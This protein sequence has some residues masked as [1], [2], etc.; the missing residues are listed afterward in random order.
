MGNDAGYDFGDAFA[1][2]TMLFEEA[3]GVASEGQSPR[4]GAG[5]RLELITSLEVMLGEAACIFDD[6]KAAMKE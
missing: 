1:R 5:S 4:V 6:V 3:A 2:L